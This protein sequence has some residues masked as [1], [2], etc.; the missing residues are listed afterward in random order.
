MNTSLR[1]IGTPQE[2]E[3]SVSGRKTVIGLDQQ[4]NEPVLGALKKLALK[5]LSTAGDTITFDVEDPDK[6]N[7]SVVEAIV[8]AG[9][10]VRSINVVGSTLEDTYLKLVR[11]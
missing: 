11:K 1:A 9:G 3:R 10:H 5:N 4:V 7:S 6:E 2:L 8:L